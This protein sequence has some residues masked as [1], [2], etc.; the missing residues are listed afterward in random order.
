MVVTHPLYELVQSPVYRQAGT[1]P[2]HSTGGWLSPRTAFP[3]PHW[4]HLLS[5]VT[6]SQNQGLAEPWAL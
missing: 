5:A 3:S 1:R 4:K 2:E 6:C